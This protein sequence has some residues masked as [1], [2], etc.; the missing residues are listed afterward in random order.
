MITTTENGFADQIRAQDINDLALRQLAERIN[1]GD[2]E[3]PTVNA[4]V[5]RDWTGQVD[6]GCPSIRITFWSRTI[7]GEIEVALFDAGLVPHRDGT[8][9]YDHIAACDWV[10]EDHPKADVSYS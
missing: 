10:F 5:Y 7:P 6:D 4:R 3:C 2:L 1:R 9:R 8:S